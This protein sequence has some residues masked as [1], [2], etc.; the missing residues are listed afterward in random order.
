MSI[1]SSLSGDRDPLFGVHRAGRGGGI[2]GPLFSLA[3]VCCLLAALTVACTPRKERT[4]SKS[5][6]IMDTLVT[7]TVVTDT[8][9]HANEALEK[10]FREIERLEEAADFYSP[11]SE[12]SD[13]NR[14]AGVAPVT[15]SSD[16]LEIL[17]TAQ[18]VSEKTDGAFDI[19]IGSVASLYDFRSQR[20]PPDA[21]IVEKL[22]L[23]NYR[24]MIIDREQ[25]TVFL[26]KKGMLIDTGGI[27]K[28]YAAGKAADILLGNGIRSGIVAVGGDIRTFGRRVDGTP[29]RIG[30]RDPRGKGRD[31]VIGVI[32]LSDVAISTSGDYERFF[33][34]GP[35]RFHH[36]I[37][38][39]TGFPAMGCQSVSVISADGALADAF[40]TGIFILGRDKG[41]HI[42]EQNGLEGVIIDDE[43]VIH[44]T[45]GIRGR[46]ELKNP[47]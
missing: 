11:Q 32:G 34:Q 17:L 25:S 46:I 5:R 30:I 41:M 38:P 15:V 27:M 44:V 45:R 10:A 2:F 18:H 37:S 28:G 1:I 9:S 12:I 3:A 21:E 43:G 16:I 6:T 7:V 35:R 29:W 47:L 8:E 19:T 24:D 36:L 14:H 22:S 23:V 13:I 42:L 33:L 20:V 26:R 39:R 31:E 40:S 4:F